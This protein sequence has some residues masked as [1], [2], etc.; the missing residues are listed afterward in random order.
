MTPRCGA[1][2]YPVGLPLSGLKVLNLSFW[3][4]LSEISTL[5]VCQHFR[6]LRSSGRVVGRQ[7]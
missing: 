2:P 7:T 3:R 4:R 6:C 5:G 1:L